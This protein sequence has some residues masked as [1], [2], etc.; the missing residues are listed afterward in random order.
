MWRNFK[1][2]Y[3]KA[4]T[5]SKQSILHKSILKTKLRYFNIYKHG[6]KKKIIFM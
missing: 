3:E 5:W 2:A 1:E 4:R 6:K